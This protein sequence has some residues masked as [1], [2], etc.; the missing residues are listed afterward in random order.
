MRNE[1]IRSSKVKGI[2]R[3]VAMVKL[4]LCFLFTL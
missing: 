3:V 1:D 2:K 4:P